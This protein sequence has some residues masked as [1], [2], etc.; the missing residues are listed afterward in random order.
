MRKPN[1]IQRQIHRILMIRPVTE[2]LAPRTKPLDA[3]ALKLTGGKHTLTELAGWNIIHVSTI[4]MKSGREIKIILVAVAHE[5]TLAV[6]ASNFG[7]PNHPKWYYNLMNKPECKVQ[8]NGVDQV[9][10]ARE[11]QGEEREKFWQL[12]VAHYAGYEKY[13]ERAAPRRIPVVLLEPRK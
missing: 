5:E 9:Y 10:V 3:F 11:A 2:F 1:F 13:K 12:A 7:R 4:S 8:L 6:I